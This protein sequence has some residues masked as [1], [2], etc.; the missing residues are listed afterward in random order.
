VANVPASTKVVRM[1]DRTRIVVSSLFDC[2]CWD[3]LSKKDFDK[4]RFST[5]QLVEG[6]SSHEPRL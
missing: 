3:K 6:V 1:L 2:V 4:L 5:K